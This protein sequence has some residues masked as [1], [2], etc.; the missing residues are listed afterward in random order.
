[1]LFLPFMT[2]SLGEAGFV[3]EKGILDLR[4]YN[5]ENDGVIPLNGDW[6]FYWGQLISTPD[7]FKSLQPDY[8]QVPDTWSSEKNRIIDSKYGFATY[9]LQVDLGRPVTDLAIKMG[10][11]G[12][13]NKVFINGVLLGQAGRVGTSIEEDLPDQ[14]VQVISFDA[15][16]GKVDIVIQI[17]NFHSKW[18]GLGR[19][20]LL[21]DGVSLRESRRNLEWLDLFLVGAIFIMGLYHVGLYFVRTRSY[22]PL[23]FALFC[24]IVALRIITNENFGT[25]IIRI[26]PFLHRRIDYLTFYLAFGLFFYYSNRLFPKDRK[27]WV[28]KIVLGVVTLFSLSVVILPLRIYCEG[29]EIFQ[30]FTFLCMV[31]LTYLMI[32]ATKNGRFGAKIYLIGWLL[33]FITGI[34]DLLHFSGFI[35]STPIAHIGILLFIL[36]Q[37]YLLMVRYERTIKRNVYLAKKIKSVNKNLEKIVSDRTKDLAEKNKSIT[38]SIA[39]AQELQKATL[40]LDSEIAEIFPNFFTLLKPKN[41]VS[42]DFYWFSHLKNTVRGRVSIIILGDC[43]GEGVSGGLI[44]MSAAAILDREVNSHSLFSP[45]EIAATLNNSMRTVLNQTQAREAGNKDGM[46]ASI[47]TIY[48]DE[49][50]ME[51]VGANRPLLHIN[52]GGFSI[53]EPTK[54]SLGGNFMQVDKSNFDKHRIP[55]AGTRIFLFSKGLENQ[56]GGFDGEEFGIQNIQ[57]EILQNL[58]APFK[59][60]GGILNERIEN[61]IAIGE[62]KQEDDILLIG[63]DL[64]K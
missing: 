49:G 62:V 61:W 6:E 63:F 27:V 53:A 3:A 43:T 19:E 20:I 18:G 25:D 48:H 11:F 7:S 29:L 44:S 42:A 32:L 51:Y 28:V 60:L 38:E 2:F 1:M 13:N 37:A 21:G 46:D 45:D 31:Y 15:P 54:V 52:K 55:S 16:D 56:H 17:S 30:A 10:T 34:N 35:E 26:N 22:S 5:F 47:C 24:F 59:D 58:S 4:N 12:L 50:I 57:E 39:Y 14:I 41:I 36:T 40:P 33:L 23:I 64:P 9:R 8:Y